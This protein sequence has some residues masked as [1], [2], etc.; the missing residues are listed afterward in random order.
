MGHLEAPSVSSFHP[1]CEMQDDDHVQ[2]VEKGKA[3]VPL[4]PE[5]FG[6]TAFTA[7]DAREWQEWQE[8]G[9]DYNRYEY[10]LDEDE[11]VQALMSSYCSCSNSQREHKFHKAS[12]VQSSSGLCQ[13]WTSDV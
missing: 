9:Q 6:A 4:V 2:A 10:E 1:A 12:V 8:Y 7:E 3:L 11:E 13:G 5:N